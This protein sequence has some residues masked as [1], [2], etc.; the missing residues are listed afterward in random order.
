MKP[1]QEWKHWTDYKGGTGNL[2]VCRLNH[3][4]DGAA[5]IAVGTSR[6]SLEAATRNAYRNLKRSR[7]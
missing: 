1:L 7:K 3:P 2:A 6:I 5:M 4:G